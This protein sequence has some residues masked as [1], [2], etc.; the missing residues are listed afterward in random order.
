MLLCE[1]QFSGFF[2]LLR[3]ELYFKT[4][5]RDFTIARLLLYEHAYVG[6]ITHFLRYM[7]KVFTYVISFFLLHRGALVCLRIFVWLYLLTKKSPVSKH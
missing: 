6:L 2:C 1:H 5:V 4:T 3:T 7:Y